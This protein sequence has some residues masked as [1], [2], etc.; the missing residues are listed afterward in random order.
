[1][2]QEVISTQDE[3]ISHLFFH[4]CYKDGVFTKDE[5]NNI[6]SKIVGT[7]INAELNFT[8]EI[9]KYK[10]YRAEITNDAQYLAFLV[11]LIRPTNELA[12]F[13]YCV[14]LLL[15]DSS[16]ETSEQNLIEHLADALVLDENEKKSVQKL[17][18]QRKIVETQKI[19]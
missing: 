13:S 14:E 17:M 19:I 12:L 18:V 9:K 5:I 16:I 2:Y 7:G 11:N 1:M 15:S 10:S 4:C 3:A 8:E 6:S